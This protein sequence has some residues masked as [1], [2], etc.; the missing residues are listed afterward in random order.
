MK[1]ACYFFDSKP[2]RCAWFL[3]LQRA[4]VVGILTRHDFMPEHILGL[5]P[6]L[7]KSKWKRLRFRRSTLVKFSRGFLPGHGHSNWNSV[8]SE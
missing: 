5:H 2:D 7:R 4:P 6:F 1:S 3:M 8:D